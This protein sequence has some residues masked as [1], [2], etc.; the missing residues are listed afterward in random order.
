[1]GWRAKTQQ[2]SPPQ[3]A[4]C[5]WDGD[6]PLEVIKAIIQGR[7]EVSLALEVKF[8]ITQLFY[9]NLFF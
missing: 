7:P 3:T 5:I 6:F 9:D 4:Q 2:R 8:M 1:M